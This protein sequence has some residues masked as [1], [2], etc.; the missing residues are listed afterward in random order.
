MNYIAKTKRGRNTRTAATVVAIARRGRNLPFR[1]FERFSQVSDLMLSHLEFMLSQV[2]EA[3][4]GAPKLVQ[5]QA[6][7]DLACF[8]RTTLLCSQCA[9]VFALREGCFTAPL[10]NALNR[11]PLSNCLARIREEGKSASSG[12]TG[13][14]PH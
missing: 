4:P 7:K 3:R 6:V 2:S 9:D 11:L 1:R 14:L 5:L 8:S 13:G 12:R 10:D